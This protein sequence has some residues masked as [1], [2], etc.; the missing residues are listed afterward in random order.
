MIKHWLIILFYCNDSAVESSCHCCYQLNRLHRLLLSFAFNK[1]TPIITNHNPSHD[2]RYGFI[3]M[4]SKTG[5]NLTFISV[6]NTFFYSKFASKK[7]VF[8]KDVCFCS[9]LLLLQ[10]YFLNKIIQAK[11]ESERGSA[12]E[13]WAISITHIIF[14]SYY[15]Y[16]YSVF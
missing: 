14:I 9:E 13:W 3:Q 11:K 1:N 12:R 5:M 7:N 15:C 4:D 2:S 8:R 10:Y 6:K 16:E